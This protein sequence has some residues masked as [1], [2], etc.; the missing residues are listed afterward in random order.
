[1]PKIQKSIPSGVIL[2]KGYGNAMSMPQNF[3]RIGDRFIENL[4][5]R[6]NIEGTAQSPMVPNLQLLA[7]GMNLLMNNDHLLPNADLIE[8]NIEKSLMLK[9]ESS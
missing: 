8:M 6:V 2:L 9:L 4:P 7:S 5:L 3:I 1:V